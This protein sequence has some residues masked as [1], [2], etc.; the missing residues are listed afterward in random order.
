VAMQ[1]IVSN[2]YEGSNPSSNFIVTS[3]ESQVLP[4]ITIVDWT[5]SSITSLMIWCESSRKYKFLCN[6]IHF[7]YGRCEE[8]ITLCLMCLFTYYHWVWRFDVR[9]DYSTNSMCLRRT[10]MDISGLSPNY[11]LGLHCTKWFNAPIAMS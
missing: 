4:V 6:W 11:Y 3:S 8:I 5:E 7:V 2:T 10:S 9:M 1:C